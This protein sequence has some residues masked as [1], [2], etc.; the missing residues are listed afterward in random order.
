MTN[1]EYLELIQEVNRLRAQIHIF[2]DESISEQALDDLKHKITIYE[3]NHPKSISPDSPNYTIAGGVLE[4]FEKV[5]HQRRMLSL[6]DIFDKQELEDWQQRYL[7]LATKEEITI[8][9]K[10]NNA[11]VLEPK[12][13]GLAISLRYINGVLFQ[14]ATRGDSWVGEDVTANVRM[15]R[16]IPNQIEYSGELEVRGEVFITKSDFEKLNRAISSG[17]KPGRMSKTGPE[18]VFAN[19]RN[20]AAGT[21][22]QL[23]SSVVAGRNLS[24]IAYGAYKEDQTRRS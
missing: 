5:S 7:D 2:N 6:S 22:R 11:Y 13:D 23:D 1:K 16:A 14:A 21:L 17:K 19:A 18:Y 4:K 3:T 15:I 9:N 20:A 10:S 24:F 12:I 8:Q